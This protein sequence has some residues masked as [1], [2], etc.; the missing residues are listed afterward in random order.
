V[1]RLERADVDAEQAGDAERC[2]QCGEAGIVTRYDDG[3]RH[4]HCAPFD[5]DSPIPLELTEAAY[6]ALDALG[7]VPD[8]APQCSRC[9]VEPAVATHCDRL[10]QGCI[11]RELFGDDAA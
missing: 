6:T 11:R 10:G 5:A 3:Y 1:E 8:V 4:A 2:Y 9:H 7:E